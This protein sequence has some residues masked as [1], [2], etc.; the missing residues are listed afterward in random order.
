VS[1]DQ[2]TS[3]HQ[4]TKAELEAEIA[5]L[6]HSVGDTVEA[7]TYKLDVRS[8]AQERIRS[9]PPAVPIGAAAALAL[10]IGLWLW[11]R[12]SDGR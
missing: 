5:Q 9:V 8:R 10:G 11:R 12:N 6:R 7:L 2:Q 3:H 4:P 1:T